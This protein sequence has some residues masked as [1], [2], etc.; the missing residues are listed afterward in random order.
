VLEILFK[1]YAL[2]MIEERALARMIAGIGFGCGFSIGCK[3]SHSK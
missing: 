1:F 3:K 2:L